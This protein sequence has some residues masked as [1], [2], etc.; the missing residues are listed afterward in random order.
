M[1]RNM[2]A[3]K[4][5]SMASIF[6]LVYTAAVLI[7]EAPEYWRANFASAKISPFFIDLN[8]VISFEKLN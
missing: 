2:D 5:I 8:I 4:Y 7:I 6:S 1:K 3:F